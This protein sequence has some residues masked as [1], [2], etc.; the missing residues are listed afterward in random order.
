MGVG[1]RKREVKKENEAEKKSRKWSKEESV[2]LRLL[3]GVYKKGWKEMQQT[4][5][6]DRT[7]SQYRSHA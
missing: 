6:I 2:Y 3:M 7:T 1:S 4:G 5:L